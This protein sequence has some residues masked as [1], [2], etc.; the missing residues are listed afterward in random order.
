MSN[1]PRVTSVRFFPTGVIN[2]RHSSSNGS[3]GVF[4]IS[5][6]KQHIWFASASKIT[7]YAMPDKFDNPAKPV[8]QV[9]MLK[10]ESHVDL[11]QLRGKRVDLGKLPANQL[12]IVG[13]LEL[14]GKLVVN[15]VAYYDT[16]QL[17]Q[18]TIAFRVATDL[19]N[20]AIDGPYT[21]EGRARRTGAMH[22]I[23][24]AYQ[25]TF[26]GEAISLAGKE[27]IASRYDVGPSMQPFDYSQLRENK[28]AVSF[29]ALPS[30]GKKSRMFYPREDLSKQSSDS[31][32]DFHNRHE[33]AGLLDRSNRSRNILESNITI[34]KPDGS[35]ANNDWWNIESK[36]LFAF[37]IAGT[38]TYLVGVNVTGAFKEP[39]WKGAATLPDDT[40]I[41]VGNSKKGEAYNYKERGLVYKRRQEWRY[42]LRTN[43]YRLV[44]IVGDGYGD[45]IQGNAIVRLFYFDLLDLQKVSKGEKDA[46][47][48]YPY[49]SNYMWGVDVSMFV[50]WPKR[51]DGNAWLQGRA[52][53]SMHFDYERNKAYFSIQR[54]AGYKTQIC[55]L[56][57]EAEMAI[58]LNTD[59]Y[60][61]PEIELYGDAPASIGDNIY[62]NALVTGGNKGNHHQYQWRQ[63]KGDRA[64]FR[65]L[66]Q[67][68]I[69]VQ[70]QGLAAQTLGFEFEVDDGVKRHFERT[71]VGV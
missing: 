61:A 29:D 30:I 48:V 65:V 58:T 8:S 36:A 22:H 18:T 1:L 6:N 26:G 13:L 25:S 38:R 41:A 21:R 53:G 42:N 44:D 11:N 16:R 52:P 15:F 45:I 64:P 34:K 19:K 32:K 7:Q 63:F 35:D 62:I 40:K 24:K 2:M 39:R 59:E 67:Y 56:L 27:S 51:R 47:D 5:E 31:F 68:D 14:Q 69:E 10:Y 54:A 9:E 57:V 17:P 70:T 23:P 60:E 4:A 43:Q 12:R 3:N 50:G 49:A 71:E 46:W 20:S 66:S 37:P 33:Y 55:P 28:G